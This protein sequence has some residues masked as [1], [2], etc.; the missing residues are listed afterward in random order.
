M[1]KRAVPYALRLSALV[2]FALGLGLVSG[3]VAGPPF[4]TLHLVFAVIT[5]VL[6]LVVLGPQLRRSFAAGLGAWFPLIPLVLGLLWY[7]GLAIRLIGRAG[8]VVILIHAVFG[9]IAIGL[10]EMGI[11]RARRAGALERAREL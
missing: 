2:T 10:I 11:A 6:A 4:T 1:E 8:F 7:S 3:I 5:V 9:I